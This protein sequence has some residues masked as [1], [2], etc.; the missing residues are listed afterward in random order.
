MSDHAGWIGINR[1]LLHFMRVV[2]ADRDE[3]GKFLVTGSIVTFLG[4]GGEDA[5][6]DY[7]E[8]QRIAGHL[9]VEAGYLNY[10]RYGQEAIIGLVEIMGKEAIVTITSKPELNGEL[11]GETTL[12]IITPGESVGSTGMY[13][14]TAPRVTDVR[15]EFIL[16]HEDEMRAGT[17][18]W[19][20]MVEHSKVRHQ[21]LFNDW[22][23]KQ[24]TMLN[25][26]AVEVE[27]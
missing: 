1:Q 19:D 12:T 10:A 14:E 20:D 24:V 26:Q 13:L 8:I 25:D 2:G 22:W 5:E 16:A 27:E 9:G 7:K 21:E 11:G 18:T 23:H 15:N 4:L 6:A 3:E 17:M